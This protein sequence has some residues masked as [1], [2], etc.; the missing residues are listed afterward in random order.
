MISFKRV[1]T[2]LVS[3]I[4]ARGPHPDSIDSQLGFELIPIKL[5]INY[6]LEKLIEINYLENYSDNFGKG[7]I[8]TLV[9]KIL[10]LNND[11]RKLFDSLFYVC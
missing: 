8:A 1:G 5:R 10:G 3:G 7:I 4:Q 6:N 2:L 9:K 11:I